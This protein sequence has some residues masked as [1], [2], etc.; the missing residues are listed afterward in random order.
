MSHENTCGS[1]RKI[2]LG[3]YSVKKWSRLYMFLDKPSIFQDI[4]LNLDMEASLDLSGGISLN[5]CCQLCVLAGEDLW[6]L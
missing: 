2:R 1:D 4:I 3:L 5:D 6:D